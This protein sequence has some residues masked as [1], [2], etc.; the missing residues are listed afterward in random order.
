MNFQQF[1]QAGQADTPNLI[2]AQI[3]D[4]RMDEMQQQ[5]K[6]AMMGKLAQGG[7]GL[8]NEAM[9]DNTPIADYLGLSEPT[10]QFA[11]GAMDYALP[12]AGASS[13]VNTAALTEALRAPEMASAVG[14]FAMT[15]DLLAGLAPEAT[16]G[17]NLGAALAPEAA[18]GL[19][20]ALAPAATAGMNAGTIGAALAPAAAEVGL[21][22]TAAGAAGTALPPLGIALALGSLFGL[23]G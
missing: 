21:G 13:G 20:T 10:G 11:G 15:P 22:A 14:D 7:A 1:K 5:R 23:F 4:D 19:G 9:G 8:Y 3:A 2:A 12:E 17:M 16:A 18:A 6:I